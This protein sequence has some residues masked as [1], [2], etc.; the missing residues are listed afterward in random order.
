MIEF[1]DDLKE[2]SKNLLKQHALKETFEAGILLREN[3]SNLCDYLCLIVKGEI[4]AYKRNAE[5]KSVMLY[6]VKN[7]DLCLKN[8]QCVLYDKTYDAIAITQ[9]KSEVYMIPKHIVKNHLMADCAFQGFINKVLL[10][11]IDS[12]V[13]HYEA[14]N[15]APVKK[16]LML[17]LK[18]MSLQFTRFI[19]YT[20]HQKI[21]DEINASR[22]EV[23]R[24]LKTLEKEKL[25]E[26]S[27]GKIKII[28]PFSVM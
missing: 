24:S 17:Y 26:L 7:N 22:E 27:R 19:I 2:N 10:S 20:T 15:F 14:I 25:I 28:K 16:R 6:D 21:A 9:S 11:K 1:Y 3:H 23:S 18:E 5:G 4:R 8:L 13:D 12:L